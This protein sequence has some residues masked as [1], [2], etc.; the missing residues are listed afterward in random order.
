[1]VTGLSRKGSDTGVA[2]TARQ[3]YSPAQRSADLGKPNGVKDHFI[4][5]QP[6]IIS[7]LQAFSLIPT[8]T[9]GFA[10]LRPGL[11]YRR[12]FGAPDCLGALDRLGAPF[13]AIASD[14]TR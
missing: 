1:V 14:R 7:A 11:Y 12:A 4:P 10:A 2:P 5:A 9:Q 8:Q 3:E 13:I 6:S